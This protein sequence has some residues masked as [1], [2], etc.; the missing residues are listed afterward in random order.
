MG[1]DEWASILLGQTQDKIAVIDG[2]GEYVY[3]NEASADILGYEPDRLVGENAFEYVHGD[4]VA[5]IE[6]QF[7]RIVA[8]EQRCSETV[9]YRH[10]TADG[11]WTWLESRVASAD[12]T[13]DASDGGS[14]DGDANATRNDDRDAI[15]PDETREGYVVSSRD[16]SE[17]VAAERERRRARRRLETITRAAGDVLWLFSGDWDELLFVNPAYEEVY[18]QP[19]AELEGDPTSFLQTVH[20]DDVAVVEEAMAR[21]SAGESVDIEYRV[22]PNR[23]YDRWVWAQAKPIVADGE[24]TR[25][26]GFTR[27][28]TDRRRRERQLAVMDNLLRHNLRNDMCVVLGNA[29]LIARDV[30]GA[31]NGTDAENGTETDVEGSTSIA[32]RA[33]LIRQHGERLLESAEKQRRIIDL[34][35]DYPVPKPIDVVEVTTEVVERTVEEHSVGIETDLPESA[36]AM[37]IDELDTAV[38]ELLENA[39]EHAPDGRPELS[40]SVRSAT[41]DAVAIAI[42]DDCPPIPEIEFRVLTGE[43]EMNDVY[44][45]SGLGLWLVY[46]IVD[47]SD[48]W[49]EFSRAGEDDG[50]ETI[51]ATEADGDGNTITIYLPAATDG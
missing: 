16:I 49:I 31:E 10:R 11:G 40:V 48:G 12:I 20:P 32:E 17:R 25:I 8:A 44:H 4:D 5:A 1:A 46:W 43:W 36:A 34:L 42:E 2:S 47:L 18:G 21:V 15:D 45:T 38:R 29:E 51:E 24:V 14:G 7:E 50:E 26:A 35:T 37:T 6:S 9:R 3:V 27:D 33:D 39:I 19:I 30:S 41:D 23:D 13:L 22:N 28:I